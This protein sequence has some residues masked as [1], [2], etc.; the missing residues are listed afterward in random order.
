VDG[1]VIDLSR[2][3]AR[4]LEMERRGLAPVRLTVIEV[5]ED[6]RAKWAI[7]VGGLTPDQGDRL[8]ERLKGAGPRPPR[9]IYRWN[10][11]PGLSQ[12]W[13]QGYAKE[14]EARRLA[15][16]LREEGYPAFLVR[17]RM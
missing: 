7:V 15:N 13:V 16:R 5:P 2:G 12:V 10:G 11:D 17:T 4:A 1:R 6:P 8:A 14:A 3:A 9:V